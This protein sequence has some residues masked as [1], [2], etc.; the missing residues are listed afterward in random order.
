MELNPLLWLLF[1]AQPLDV[2]SLFRQPK[3]LL[4]NVV[5]DMFIISETKMVLLYSDELLFGCQ[6]FLNNHSLCELLSRPLWQ[7]EPQPLPAFLPPLLP[8]QH[9]RL[10]K[11]TEFSFKR[12]LRI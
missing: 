4:K 11:Q 5:A 2:A 1:G 8:F 9:V 3:S 10:S 12:A 7:L 6:F